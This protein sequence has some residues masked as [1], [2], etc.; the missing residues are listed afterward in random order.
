MLVVMGI[1][2]LIATF[3]VPAMRR[4]GGG[5]VV[6]QELATLRSQMIA[7]RKTAMSS[8]RSVAIEVPGDLQYAPRLPGSK[9]GVLLFYSDGSSTG[10]AIR[11][12]DRA[13][14]TIDW[15]SGEVR[16]AGT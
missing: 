9:A 13:L 10:G 8:G 12:N 3:A 16:H 7:A 4:Q 2:A 1:L 15:L 6:Q 11:R 5:V 14:L